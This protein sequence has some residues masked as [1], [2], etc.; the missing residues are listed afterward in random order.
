MSINIEGIFLRPDFTEVITESFAKK[1]SIDLIDWIYPFAYFNQYDGSLIY[2]ELIPDGCYILLG[3]VEYPGK[4]RYSY[5]IVYQFNA[6]LISGIDVKFVKLF[7]PY[8]DLPPSIPLS[9]NFPLFRV[10]EQKHYKKFRLLFKKIEKE[11][12]TRDE[13][14]GILSKLDKNTI[15]YKAYALKL[16][17]LRYVFKDKELS[18]L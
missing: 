15:E 17:L 7:T 13:I 14:K 3:K 6:C 12:L 8:P 18:W 16:A 11:W 2:N 9:P 1:Y 4:D 10:C 5:H